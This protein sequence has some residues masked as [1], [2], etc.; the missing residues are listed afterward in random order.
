MKIHSVQ[1]FSDRGVCGATQKRRFEFKVAV[2]VA[3]Q[4]RRLKE[5]NHHEYRCRMCGDWHVGSSAT[6]RRPR[7]Q[8]LPPSWHGVADALRGLGDAA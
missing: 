5:S 8:P 1:Q 7:R 2:A 3:R 4:M 6:G